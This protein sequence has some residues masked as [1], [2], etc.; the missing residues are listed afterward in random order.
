M[1]T[2]TTLLVASTLALAPKPA[3][4]GNDGLAALGGFVGGVIV[5][6]TLNHHP[7]PVCQPGPRV[8]IAPPAPVHCNGYWKDVTVRTW[9]PGYWTM[10]IHHGRQIRFY[11]DGHYELRTDRIWVDT[12]HHD[13][14]AYNH[15]R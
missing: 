14:H 9:V 15:R 4:A 11:V 5:G 2:L 10:R 3:I 13:R 1:K 6:S 7:A 12:R 8:I